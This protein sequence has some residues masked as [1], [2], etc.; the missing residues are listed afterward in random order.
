MRAA[1]YPQ[2]AASSCAGDIR[3]MTQRVRSRGE[4]E[5]PW[6]SSRSLLVVA[7]LFA[8]S[9]GIAGQNSP[10]DA[11]A[12]VLRPARVFDG[13]AMHEGW[14]VR[15]VGDHIDAVGPTASINVGNARVVDLA[16]L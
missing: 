5:E 3:Q 10:S 14:A 1:F 2:C 7:L 12:V 6:M 15:I 4:V 16:G 9:V 13:A 8:A 11:N